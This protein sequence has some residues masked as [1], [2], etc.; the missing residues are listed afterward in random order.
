MKE[1]IIEFNDIRDLS[2]CEAF[3]G[4]FQNETVQFIE[5]HFDKN[6]NKYITKIKYGK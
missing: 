2:R 5:T 1:K 3:E 6:K 4:K